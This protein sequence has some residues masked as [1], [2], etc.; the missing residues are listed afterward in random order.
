M[1]SVVA[2]LRREAELT[3]ARTIQGAWF[4]CYYDPRYTVC[5][6][7]IGRQYLALTAA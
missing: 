3:A 4:R 2:A 6:R 5:R 1:E 7:R